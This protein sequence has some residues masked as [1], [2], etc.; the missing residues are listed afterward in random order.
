[1]LRNYRKDGSLFYNELTLSP[2]CDVAGKVTHFVGFQT[3]VNAQERASGLMTR[4]QVMTQDL[5]A[6]FT[7]AEVFNLILRD[8]LEALGGISGAVSLVQ[9]ER[10]HIAARRGHDEASVWQD[11][12]LG[13]SAPS[14][15]ALRANTPLLLQ[16][17]R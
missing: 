15:D 6:V 11:R 5:A 16:R 4:L 13:D 2:I 3:D 14:P 7:Q 8:A 1:M 17:Q 10:L 12:A 9:D